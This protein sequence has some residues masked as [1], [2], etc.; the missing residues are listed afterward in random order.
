MPI[1]PPPISADLPRSHVPLLSPDRLKFKSM[2]ILPE[3]LHLHQN[4]FLA[5]TRSLQPPQPR[6]FPQARVVAGRTVFHTRRVGV[7]GFVKRSES[8]EIVMR[9]RKRIDVVGRVFGNRFGHVGDMTT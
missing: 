7:V 4:V 1:N 2:P 8:G 5:I 6:S 9:R 3:C